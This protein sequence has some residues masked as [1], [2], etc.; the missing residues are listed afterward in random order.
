MKS[1]H[2]LVV[3][4]FMA[5]AAGL[6]ALTLAY[7]AVGKFIDGLFL[8]GAVAVALLGWWAQKATGEPIETPRPTLD[9]EVRR[10]IRSDFAI[11]FVTLLVFIGVSVWAMSVAGSH[12]DR[13]AERSWAWI[14][15]ALVAP[16]V[17]VVVV[18]PRISR[19]ARTLLAPIEELDLSGGKVDD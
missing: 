15:V 2:T 13:T 14:A 5:L 1:S 8:V 4:G 6:A 10:L 16:M 19:I 11:V 12:Q 3:L 17:G 7:P 18:M 9:P